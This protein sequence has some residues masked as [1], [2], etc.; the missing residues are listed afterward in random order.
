MSSLTP[1]DRQV[2]KQMLETA[3]AQV[4]ALR[5]ALGLLD[6]TGKSLW[7]IAPGTYSVA[8]AAKS[9]WIT[10]GASK[11]IECIKTIREHLP[12]HGLKEVKELVESAPCCLGKYSPEDKMVKD[13]E[14]QGCVL[15]WR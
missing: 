13:L 2:L 10:A 7:L 6:V 5:A 11:K 8:E 14:A 15:D 12:H 9:Q 4:L 3:E 1:K